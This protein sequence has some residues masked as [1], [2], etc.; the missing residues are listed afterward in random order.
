VTRSELA[1]AG[2]YAP[3]MGRD[4]QHWNIFFTSGAS[5]LNVPWRWVPEPVQTYLRE[6]RT[7]AMAVVR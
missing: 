7:V 1:G 6:Q 4:V 3:T 2:F 5:V